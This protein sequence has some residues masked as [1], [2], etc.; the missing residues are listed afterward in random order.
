MTA[1]SVRIVGGSEGVVEVSAILCRP[2]ANI[3]RRVRSGVVDMKAWYGSLPEISTDQLLSKDKDLP[4]TLP[5]GTFSNLRNLAT[6]ALDLSSRIP[7][8]SALSSSIALSV[9][10]T[11]V[12][13]RLRDA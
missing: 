10:G 2:D 8:G 4:H 9:D 12:E 1:K 5:I 13:E 6:I 11:S 7:V 3:G